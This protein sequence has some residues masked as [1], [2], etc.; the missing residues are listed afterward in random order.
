MKENTHAPPRI[1]IIDD[2]KINLTVLTDYLEGSH[3]QTMTAL[4]GMNGLEKARRGQPDLILLDVMMPDMD[5]FATCRRLKADPLTAD[6]PVIFVTAL[7]SVED[8]V[9]GFNAGGVDY[10]TKPFQM[11][12]VRARVLTHIRLSRAKKQLHR[13]IAERKRAEEELRQAKEAAESATRT[14]SAFLANMSHEIRTPMNVIIGMNRLIRETELTPQQREYAEMVCH[15]SEIL[16]SLIEDILDF[17]KIEAG[18]LDLESVDFDIRELVTGTAGM[19][20]M[21]AAEKGLSLSCRIAENVPCFLKGD[22]TRLRQVIMNLVNN[23]V[24]FTEQGEISIEV[25]LEQETDQQVTLGFSVADTGIGIPADRLRD[26]FKPF[27]QVDAS[28]TRKYGGTGL[29]L[30]ISSAII[31]MMDG[32]ISVESEPGKGSTFSC[33]ACFDKA[34]PEPEETAG[35]SDLSDE[36]VAGKKE[37]DCAAVLAGLRVLL[38]EDNLFNQKL[39][40]IIL[41]KSEI[42][43]ETAVNGKEAVE[44]VRKGRYDFVLMD[45]QMPVMDGLEAARTL[46]K[47][48]IRIPIIAL[49]ANATAKDR[50][51]CLDAGMDDYI[52]K[53]VD[54]EKLQDVI[55][56]QM[57]RQGACRTLGRE[58]TVQIF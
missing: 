4:N 24:K 3:I 48:Q 32:S 21:K 16:L 57:N 27:S 13:E 29:G 51:D 30:V 38:A 19:L 12:E 28:T 46:R 17:S 26:L 5:G 14:K 56:R 52:S 6:I 23:A 44:A 35:P 45:V 43:V 9:T 15:S 36:S 25:F 42:R 34:E 58:K 33:T 47:E 54:E 31:G 41:E 49:T 50:S 11:E 40:Q 53:P 7:H 22:P 18:R 39:A 55:C 2:N 10:L 20:E 1:L 8:K 37:G